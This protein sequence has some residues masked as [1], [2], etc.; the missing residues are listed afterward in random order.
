M[1]DVC[2]F[3]EETKR[4]I[5]D[6]PMPTAFTKLIE[7]NLVFLEYKIRRE[8][9]SLGFGGLHKICDEEEIIK[10]FNELVEAAKIVESGSA[11]FKE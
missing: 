9:D 11:Y 2:R 4:I 3:L 1:I 7:G 8:K 5:I 6:F 10:V